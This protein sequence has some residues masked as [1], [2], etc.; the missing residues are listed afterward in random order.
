MTLEKF[1]SEVGTLE[2][3]FT[4]HCKEKH[5]HQKESKKTLHYNNQNI[6][7]NFYLCDE[8][9]KLISYSIKRLQEC[10]HD[11]KPR[12]RNC[13]KPC[14]K[15]KEWKALAKLMRYSGI[16]LGFLKIKKFFTV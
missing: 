8:C 15:E 5:L 4:L 9:L 2:K 11:I 3:F 13:P 10:P 14:Y 12:C 6:P 7:I 1:K 16:Q